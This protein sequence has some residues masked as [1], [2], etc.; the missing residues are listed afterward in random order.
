MGVMAWM[1]LGLAVALSANVLLPGGITRRR[2]I[3]E[4]SL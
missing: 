1:P 3:Q 4:G 2:D